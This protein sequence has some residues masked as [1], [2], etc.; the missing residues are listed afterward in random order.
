MSRKKKT[1]KGRPQSET[2]ETP[3]GT[4]TLDPGGAPY[5]SMSDWYETQTAYVSAAAQRALDEYYGTK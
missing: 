3:R 2:V 4:I 1:N 5:S